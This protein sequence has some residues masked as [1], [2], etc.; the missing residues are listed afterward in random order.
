LTILWQRGTRI[1]QNL[2]E[3]AD[4]KKNIVLIGVSDRTEI[5]SKEN[6]DKYYKQ[7]DSQFTEDQNA[8]EELGF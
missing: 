6:W 7:A 4:L 2:I 3:Y 1:P 8:F 5:W